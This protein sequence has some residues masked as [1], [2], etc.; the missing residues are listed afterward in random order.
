MRN[1]LEKKGQKCIFV[2][3]SED[4]KGYKMYDLVARKF[5]ISRNVQFV[6]NEP[7]NERITKIVKIIDAMEDTED[8]MVQ[9]P[10]IGRCVVPYTPGTTM[11][12]TVKNTPV[13]TVGVKFTPR[14]QQTSAGSPSSSTS[15]YPNLANMLPRKTRNMCDIYNEDTSNSFSVFFSVF[16][17]R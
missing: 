14:V 12:I 7:W 15:P 13:R 17:N 11:K 10:C 16:T 5:I 6:E 8:E 4:T 1:K 9:T 2:G 3:Y